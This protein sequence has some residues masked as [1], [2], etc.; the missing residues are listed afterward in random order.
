MIEAPAALQ[1]GLYARVSSEQQAQAKT[2]ASQLADLRERIRADGI[3]WE[4]VLS[5]VDQGYS[6]ATLVR[7]ALER[8]RD[9]AAAGGLDR[10]YIHCPDRLARTYTHQVVVLDELGHAGVEV[11]FLNRPVGQTPEDQLL[12]QVQGVIAE[13]ERA[14]FLERSRRG[15]RHAAQAGN[16]GILGHAPYGY[17]Y[18]SKQEGDGTARFA[19]V[20]EEARVVRDIFWWVGGERCTLSAVRRR[21]HVA[22]VL[23]RTGKAWWSHKTIWDL[24]QN[25]AYK[26]EAAY[27]KTRSG[28]LA[29]RWRA[30]R[31]RP[32]E[33]RRGYSS[34]AAPV[35]DWIVIPVPALVDASLFEAVQAQL[36]ENR[37]R[38]R[39]PLKGSRYLLQGLIVCARCGYAYYGRTNDA[40]NAYYR[41]SASDA[42]RCGG[43]QLCSNAEIRMDVVDQAVWHEVSALLQEPTRL[44]QEYRRRL[45]P[46]TSTEEHDHTLAH[47]TKLR[48]GIA[49]LIDS[50]AEGLIEKTEFEPRV[51]G[52]RERLSQAEVDLR[53][54]QEEAQVQSE[55]RMLVGRLEQFAAQVRTGLHDAD[56]QT[57]RELIRTLVKRVEIDEQQIRVVFRLAPLE[58]PSPF[59]SAPHN[60]QHCG[61]RV[62]EAGLQPAGGAPHGRVGQPAAYAGGARAQDRCQGCRVA[63]G[64]AGPWPAP[65]Q[66]HSSRPHTRAARTGGLSPL[67]GAGAHA[68]DQPRPQ[69]ARA[70]QYQAGSGGHRCV[71]QERTGDAAWL[72]SGR[73]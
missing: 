48:R 63:G 16:V 35:A 64:F 6:G 61:E 2:I 33:S 9:V 56:W 17:R 55:L 40:R 41:C 58:S 8:L 71:G 7:P 66:L 60:W 20:L 23:T 57:R 67:V 30:P 42:A 62:L 11:I 4:Q 22:G 32:A 47:L 18:I 50:Y 51:T 36:A 49:R 13:Y 27:G 69:A 1:V 45:L 68:G 53:R 73:P 72:G 39:I 38:A 31:G 10:L 28:P 12:V 25:P 52:L 19:V 59:D 43:T 21:L 54:L 5:F 37:Q 46:T 3:A 24:L 34:K 44:E 70:G 65:A 14:K 15:K 29:P 26:G